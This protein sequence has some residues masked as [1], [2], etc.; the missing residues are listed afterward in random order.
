[1]ETIHNFFDDYSEGAHPRILEAISTSNLTQQASYGADSYSWEA[2]SLIRE[3]IG[4]PNS[5]VHFVSGGTQAN[6]ISLASMMKPY[7]AVIAASTA[8]IN[9]HEAGA[10]EATGHKI[11]SAVTKD[12]KL[13]VYDVRR[14]FELHTDE[15]MVKPKTVFIS[16]ATE[17]GTVYSKNE[18]EELSDLC[19]RIGLYLYLDGARIG[20]A[21][22]ASG[23]GLQEISELV[24]AFYIGG[25]KN[26]AL[27]GEAI[28]VNNPTLQEDFRYHIKQRGA[29]LAKGWLLG[30]QFRELFR[31]DLYFDLARHGNSMSDI[32]RRNVQRVGYEFLTDSPTNQ[33]FPILPLELF[34]RLREKYGFYGWRDV[35]NLK[36]AIR[37]VTSWATPEEA[38]RKFLTDLKKLS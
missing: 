21:V 13:S 34:V 27:F 20:S 22:A 24:D 1:M 8:H 33:L 31:D 38:V 7:E 15:H 12:G 9:L 2:A 4:N 35:G 18:L 25:T 32:L 29:L 10:I 37:L 11:I 14:I 28:V 26:G 5:A 36:M 17:L 23:V 19:R 16:N 6:I 30:I 3:R